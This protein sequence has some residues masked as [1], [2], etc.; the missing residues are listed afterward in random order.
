MKIL[1]FLLFVLEASSQNLNDSK[2]LV[3]DN[4]QNYKFIDTLKSETNKKFFIFSGSDDEIYINDYSLF[5]LDLDSGKLNLSKK[6]TRYSYPGKVFNFDEKILVSESRVFYGKC[7][8]DKGNMLIFYQNDLQENTNKY[9][10]SVYIVEIIENKL[11]NYLVKSNIPDISQTLSQLKI[12]KCKE[13]KGI[14]TVLPP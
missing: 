12:G 9:F 1:F 10:S 2:S 6:Y 7:L 3:I 13:I 14:K 8:P 11:S 4:L 5:I